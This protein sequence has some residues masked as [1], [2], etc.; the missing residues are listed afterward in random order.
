MEPTR[1]PG[2][3]ELADLAE[4]RWWL[5]EIGAALRLEEQVYDRLISSGRTA[6]AAIR[7]ARITLMWATRGDIAV[8]QA[9][10]SRVSRIL[11]DEPPCTAHAYLAYLEGGFALSMGAEP[12]I[13]VSAAEQ[14]RA[15]ERRF[16][17]PTLQSFAL[18]LSGMAAV[19]SGDLRGFAE[20]DEAMIPVLGGRTNPLWGGDIFCTVIHLCEMVGDIGRMQAWTRTL[21][22]WATPL[23]GTFLWVGVT[24]VH[25]LQL[26]RIAGE[27]D[28][29]EREMGA[30]S[31][32]L[33]DQH[34]WVA[35]G[36][37]YELGEVHRLRG[38]A[39]DAQAAYDRAREFGIE[40]Q[41]GEAL[42][43]RA[44]GEPARAL[45]GLLVALAGA[46]ELHRARL[47]PATTSLACELGDTSLAT[48]LA[49]ELEATADRFG[50]AGLLAD[51]ARA[52]ADCLLAAGRYD[53]AD[54]ALES[55]ARLHRQQGQRHELA[56][57]HEALAAVHHARGDTSRAAAAAATARA[58]Y[59]DLGAEAG[60]ARLAAPV[61][62]SGLTAR[63]VEVL[64][65]VASGLTNKQVAEAL[66]ISDK[67]VSRHL[68]NIFTKIG[69][70]SRTAAA[71]WAHRHGM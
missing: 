11:A 8:A 1:D 16:P 69:V 20:L 58:I 2:T 44:G 60:L 29:V 31:A 54:A 71:A 12:E 43:L 70:S 67:T 38:K 27:W 55:A 62:P 57:V 33:A 34:G 56:E 48:R 18:A 36:G 28:V 53:D 30:Q 14:V 66:V 51:A 5:G 65:Q 41:P 25:Q 19:S 35:G 26:L 59:A 52:R 10:M 47:I 50:T 21:T 9:W 24:R 6:D 4:E 17:D 68:D 13:V 7:G 39:A 45:D 23:S 15:I 46:S 49:D 37:Y 22:D 42:L 63:E 32:A 40:P 61:A 3:D 64:A